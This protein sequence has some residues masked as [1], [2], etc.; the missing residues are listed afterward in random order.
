MVVIYTWKGERTQ[1]TLLEVQ[2]IRLVVSHEVLRP[3]LRASQRAM[4]PLIKR[5]WAKRVKTRATS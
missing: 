5:P 1:S 2:E 4:H 3:S